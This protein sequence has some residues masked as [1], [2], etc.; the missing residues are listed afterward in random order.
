MKFRNTNKEE[1]TLKDLNHINTTNLFN[2]LH[3]YLE[4]KRKDLTK[5]LLNNDIDI[6]IFN[7]KFKH[8]NLKIILKMH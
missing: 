4:I 2:N 3:E 5:E 8:L 7:M 1:Y 6:K